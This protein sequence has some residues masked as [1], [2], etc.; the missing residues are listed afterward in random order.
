MHDLDFS[1]DP[2]SDRTQNQDMVLKSG[3]I[4]VP[5]LPKQQ[6]DPE[7]PTWPFLVMDAPDIS[8]DPGCSRATKPN[9][10]L[11]CSSGRTSL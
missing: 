7:T 6:Y 1:T 11:S 8:T 10:A 3:W 2:S 4:S 5:L 9:I